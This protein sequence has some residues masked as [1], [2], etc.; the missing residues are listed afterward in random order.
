MHGPVPRLY[1]TETRRLVHRLAKKSQ[2]I[3]QKW[4]EVE[5]LSAIDVVAVASFGELYHIFGNLS[6]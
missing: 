4:F 2:D 5:F 3:F 1:S 6:K